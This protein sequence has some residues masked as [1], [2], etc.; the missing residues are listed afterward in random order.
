MFQLADLAAVLLAC[1][2]KRQWIDAGAIEHGKALYMPPAR[3][4][5][6]LKAEFK[7]RDLL[8]QT[9]Y[10]QQTQAAMLSRYDKATFLLLPDHNRLLQ[11]FHDNVLPHFIS[12]DGGDTG[13]IDAYQSVL[14]P[15]F[16]DLLQVPESCQKPQMTDLVVRTLIDLMAGGICTPPSGTLASRPRA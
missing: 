11:E 14:G 6:E 3:G 8:L 7:L 9:Q 1:G 15:E 10:Q 2:S 4:D 5:H 12:S 16:K 13:A